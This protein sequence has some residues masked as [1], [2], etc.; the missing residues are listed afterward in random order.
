[1]STEFLLVLLIDADRSEKFHF[2][3]FLGLFLVLNILFLKN[4]RNVLMR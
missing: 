3:S 1:M 2:L 4:E